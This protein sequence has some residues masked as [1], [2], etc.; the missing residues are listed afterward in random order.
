M[1][2]I[3]LVRHGESLWNLENRFTGWTDIDLSE[4]GIKEAREAGKLLKEKGYTFDLAYTSLL[5]RT[6]DTLFLILDEMNLKDIE[7]RESYLLNERHYGALQGMNKDE[8]R[9]IYGEEQVKLWRRSA[10]T[11][12]PLLTYDDPRFPGNDPKYS[13][14]NKEDLPLGENLLDTVKRVSKYWEEEIKNEIKNNRKIIVAANGNSSRAL[15]MYLENIS[16][17]DIMSLEIKTGA[18]IV[19]EFD[20]D[21]KP[22]RRYYL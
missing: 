17:E 10:S 22:I 18:P 8:A 3:V 15:I 20:D 14:I 2:K 16:E 6:K 9:K 13:N 7:I 21:L 1:Y 5:K 4:N 12:P 11:R 19:Y